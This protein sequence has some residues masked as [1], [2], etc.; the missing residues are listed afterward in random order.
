MKLYHILE[1]P[2]TY[3]PEKITLRVLNLVW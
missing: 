3:N 2:N 1:V